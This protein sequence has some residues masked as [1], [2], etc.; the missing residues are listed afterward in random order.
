MDLAVFDQD[1]LPVALRAL[2]SVVASNGTITAAE[3]RFI[4]VIAQL[5][6]SEVRLESL[7]SIDASEVAKVIR[8]PH[9]R[10]R[11]VQLAVIAA[12]VEGEVTSKEAATV[13]VLAGALGVD[14]G[15][16]RV[17]KE[18]AGHHR[19][20]TRI[21]MSRRILGK[22]GSQAYE[23]EGLAGIRKMLVPF[24]GGEDP[25]VAW[26]YKSLGL[27]PEGTLGRVFWEHCT[28]RR[29][30]F[31]GEK[32]GIPERMV[33]HDFGHVLAGYDTDP[34]GEIQQ[35]AFQAGFIREDGF[36]FL[37]FV[38]IQFHLGVKITPVAEAET[39]LFDVAKVLRAVQRGAACKVD[40]SD[41]WDPFQ[42]VHRPLADVLAEYGIPPR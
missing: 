33:F 32:G 36:A 20:L 39:G 22:F 13:D 42:V 28:R 2:R 7:E 41:H 12:M 37:L 29:F 14:E 23:E 24:T 34:E 26:K 5:H 8:E 19:L 9:P 10:K 21:D 16:L 3:Q 4:E 11:V 30:S 38:V 6:G 31:P 35:G 27:L 15:S 40:L 17:L 18:V 25:E 1:E